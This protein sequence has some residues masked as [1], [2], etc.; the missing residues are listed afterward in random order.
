MEKSD[1]KI[2][3]RIG[4]MTCVNCQN[5]IE[6]EL[7][8]S[9]GIIKVNVSYTNGTAEIVYDESKISLRYRCWMGN[10]SCDHCMA[11]RFNCC[12]GY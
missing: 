7:N 5:K 11:E 10:L 9:R 2:Q 12:L 6:K 8:H 1:K 4:G 3:P